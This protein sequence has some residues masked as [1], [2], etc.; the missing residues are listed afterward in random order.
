M[1]WHSYLI[2]ANDVIGICGILVTFEGHIYCWHIYGSS[3]VTKSCNLLFSTCILS[4]VESIYRL[5][6][7]TVKHVCTMW[8][9]YLFRGI[10]Q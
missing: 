7:S 4:T 1:Y 2:S 6:K 9:E 8:Q 10:C 3:M 5:Y